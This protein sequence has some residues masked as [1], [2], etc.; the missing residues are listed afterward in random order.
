MIRC[1]AAGS[2]EKKVL[3][4]TGFARNAL[5]PDEIAARV[6]YSYDVLWWGAD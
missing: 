6:G 2:E 3:V 1:G 4:E 5:C